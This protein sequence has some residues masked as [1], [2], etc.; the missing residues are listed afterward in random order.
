MNETKVIQNG[1]CFVDQNCTFTFEG[2]AF[3]SGGAFLGIDKKTG[4]MGGLLYAFE[5]DKQ[6][7][8]WHGT[9]KINAY[10]GREYYSNMGDKRQ[11][12]YFTWHGKPFYGVYY[13]TNSDLI[14]CREVKK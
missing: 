9:I 2:K 13:K 7:G 1:P 11:S 3:T 14:R 8:N 4:K 10:F 6:V 12:V 5:K